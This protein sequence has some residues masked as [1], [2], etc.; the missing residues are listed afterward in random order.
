MTISFR[1]G[2][3]AALVSATCST[4]GVR[5]RELPYTDRE[6][7]GTKVNQPCDCHAQRRAATNVG[8]HW[9]FDDGVNT[10]RRQNGLPIW[11]C[12]VQKPWERHHST[13]SSRSDAPALRSIRRRWFFTVCSERYNRDAISLLVRPSLTN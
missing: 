6:A 7:G 10:C 12:Q 1:G 5:V 9:M 3:A 4:T 2:C 8:A 13:A 11:N